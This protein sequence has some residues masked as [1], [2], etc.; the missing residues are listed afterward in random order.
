MGSGSRGEVLGPIGRLFR[1]GS[2]TGVSDAQLLEQFLVRHDEAAEAAFAALVERHG[3]MVLAVCRRVLSDPHDAHD[4]FQATFL[5]LVRKAT[6]V[7]KRE[8]I[9]DWLHGVARRV[10][11]HA[12][13]DSARRRAIER[14]VGTMSST[15]YETI[16][17]DGE[18]WDEVDRLPRDLRSAV[19]LCYVEGLTHEQAARRLGWPVGTVR[20]RLAR[21]RDRLRARLTRRGLAP[22]AAF[23][24][25]LAVKPRSVS[26]GLIDPT[27][28]AAMLF[29]AR[30]AAETGLVS[31]SAAALTEGVLRTMFF[32]KLKVCALTLVLAGATASGAGLYAYQSPRP[33]AEPAA[34]APPH[35]QA[36]TG[37]PSAL[38]NTDPQ[39]G[40]YR[41]E[42]TARP[43]TAAG[44]LQEEIL[45]KTDHPKAGGVRIPARI[46]S[47]RGPSAVDLD[48]FAAKMQL[49][50]LD[51]SEHQS[52]GDIQRAILGVERIESFAGQWKIA[53]ANAKVSHNTDDRPP[54]R[55]LPAA[56][57]PDGARAPDPASSEQRL[58]RL[59]RAVERLVRALEKGSTENGVELKP[60]GPQQKPVAPPPP[61]V[62]GVI[63]KVD[64]PN[65]RVELTIGSDDGLVAGHELFV[66]RVQRPAQPSWDFELLGQIR[67]IAA[68]PDQSIAKV[69]ATLQG[70]IIKEGDKV[71]AQ[72]PVEDGRKPSEPS[73][74]R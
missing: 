22:D 66:Y 14:R 51:V 69:I 4:A 7:R 16:F 38:N 61:S 36:G 24:P 28:K 62:E 63:R 60:A 29:A 71:S 49:L 65:K 23:L 67:I 44:H 54:P 41:L 74:K 2:V 73:K 26:E 15:T 39:K 52:R 25:A 46:Y 18:I 21:A 34:S 27:V 35:P 5:I 33:A 64:N 12:W 56:D 53:L 55:R 20:S 1:T 70:K 58:E 59:E 72:P 42:I 57:R 47:T 11:A 10:S 50:V 13:A 37:A 45:L 48:T 31:A 30:D 68:D 8:S 19:V 6:T 3:P 9:A 32:S 17:A 40:G 43:G